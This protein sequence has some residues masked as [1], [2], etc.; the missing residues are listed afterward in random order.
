LRRQ[1]KNALQ[2]TGQGGEQQ[3]GMDIAFCAI[4]LETM[5]MSFAGAHNPLWLFRNQNLTDFEITTDSKYDFIELPADRQPVGIYLKERPFTEQKIQLEAG[6][7]F[8]IFSD[9]YH[10]QFGGKRNE[11]LKVKRFKELLSEIHQ[12][13]ISKQREILEQ[14]FNEWK[15]GYHQTDDVLVLGVRI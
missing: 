15:K 12:L 14:K 7:T 10:S 5:E 11:T 8:Y 1:I 3:D 13:P 6:D 2:Q 9:G 4:N